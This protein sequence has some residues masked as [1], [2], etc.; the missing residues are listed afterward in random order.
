MINTL[1]STRPG[2]YLA[3]YCKTPMD[4]P[5]S[6]ASAGAAAAKATEM[7]MGGS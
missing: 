3:G 4:I 7:I 2:I 5:D 1:D 6:V